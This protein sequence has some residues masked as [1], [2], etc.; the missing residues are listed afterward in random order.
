M[1]F[2]VKR[3]YD[4]VEATD[5][6][7]VLVDRLWPRGVAKAKAEL[8]EWAKEAAPSSELRHWFDH[9]AERF[10][11]FAERYRAELQGNSVVE[12]IRR[13]GEL[14]T[15]TLLYSAH[16][17]EFNQAVVLRDVLVG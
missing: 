12:A 14:G 6:Y 7:R 1:P 5:G 17:T 8:D 3:I 15:V 13:R 4:A 11:E 9:R 10:P 2:Q 16:D